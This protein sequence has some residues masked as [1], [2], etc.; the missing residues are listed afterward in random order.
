M[1]HQ[2]G[3]TVDILLG[4]EDTFGTAAADG[5]VVQINS[6]GVKA[7][8]N[9]IV[10]A[11]LTGTR[12]P[13]APA[14]GNLTVS[15]PIVIPVDSGIMP[16]WCAAMFGNPTS[17]GSNPYVHEYKIADTML[18]FTLEAAYE[19]LGTSK[20]DRFLGCKVSG[21]NI[22]VGGDGELTASL[23]IAGANES[24]ASSPFDASPTSVS[25]ARLDNFEAAILE[26]G[27]SLSNATELSINI[28]FGLD[29]DNYVIGGSGILG[30]IP[31]GIVGVSGNIKT[32]FEDTTLLEKAINSTETSLKLTITNSASSVF[33]IEIQELQYERNSPDVPGPQGLLVDL[34]FQGF[35]TNGSE[36][37]AVVM[38]VT[39]TTASYDVTTSSSPSAS[40]SASPS[41]S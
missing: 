29:L 2:K 12:N 8:R 18:S 22:T 38:R 37:S 36:A 11:T 40:V 21:F 15:G 17:T 27:G 39:N 6:L 35:Y 20:Y 16:Y 3:S 26:G 24:M 23:D 10:P 1:A 25:L 14:D 5:F 30:A 41:P 13:A 32:L 7:N 31:E 19:D 28:D 4:F 9:L 33:E 34:N